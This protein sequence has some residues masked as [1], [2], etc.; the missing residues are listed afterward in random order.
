[1]FGFWC[2]EFTLSLSQYTLNALALKHGVLWEWRRSHSIMWHSHAWLHAFSVIL[3]SL[4]ALVLICIHSFWEA[5]LLLCTLLVS[6][7]PFRDSYYCHSSLN[8]SYFHVISHPSLH[9][10]ISSCVR[11]KGEEKPV[12]YRRRYP[13][14]F[15]I[16][17]RCPFVSEIL[18]ECNSDFR[19]HHSTE[20]LPIK[21]NC[22]FCL[23]KY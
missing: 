19:F 16:I 12:F 13:V 2:T 20:N 1:M 15:Y 11:S 8:F 9:L 23:K 6:L 10:F 17:L 7:W 18:I 21:L 14:F 22:L 5:I 4:F 3:T